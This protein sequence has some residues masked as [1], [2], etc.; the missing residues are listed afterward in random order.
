[1]QEHSPHTVSSHAVQAC[2][3]AALGTL[4]CIGAQAQSPMSTS[5]YDVDPVLSG[6]M[7]AV[8]FHHSFDHDSLLPDMATGDWK[9]QPFGKPRLAPGLRGKALVAGTGALLFADPRNWTI[10]TR[11]AVAFWVSPVKWDHEAA[12]NTN[13]V[14]SQRA[15]FYVERQGP[16][17][18]PDGSWKR[19]EVLL[20]GMQRGVRGSRGAACRTW[21]PGE[22]HLIVA[23]WSWPQLALSVDGGAF[24][25]TVFPHKPDAKLFAGF[26]LGSRGGDLTLMDEFFCF[27]RP[28]SEREASSLHERLR[29]K[30]TP[31]K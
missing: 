22:W 27:S 20:V 15:A 28:L 23:N 7:D 31:A 21:Q 26:A 24:N 10:A 12:A 25:A 8:T 17:R 9:F 4:W 19:L 1:M 2:A 3:I 29:P 6:L 11:G 5:P 18:K 14:V 30:D 16:V 13:F